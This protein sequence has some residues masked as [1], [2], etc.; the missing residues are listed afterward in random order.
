MTCAATLILTHIDHYA[1]S[2]WQF[3]GPQ[4]LFD[5]TLHTGSQ[6]NYEY[7]NYSPECWSEWGSGLRNTRPE[8]RASMLHMVTWI[9][10]IEGTNNLPL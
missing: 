10:R 7:A 2:Q 5:V 4:F 6:V 1:V 3:F 8:R 9:Q